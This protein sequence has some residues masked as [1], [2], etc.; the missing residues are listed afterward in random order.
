MQ[1][2]NSEYLEAS[3]GNKKPIVVFAEESSNRCLFYAALFAFIIRFFS[4]FE[5]AG[6]LA[7]ISR[8]VFSSG[9]LS[10]PSTKENRWRLNTA[11]RFRKKVSVFLWLRER[12]RQ[13]HLF[14][15][16]ISFVIIFFDKAVFSSR[17]FSPSLSVPK[18]RQKRGKLS[19]ARRGGKTVFSLA[20]DFKLFRRKKSPEAAEPAGR[21]K[22]GEGLASG[23]P[24]ARD[25][26]SDFA[27]HLCWQFVF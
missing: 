20:E 8:S 17:R 23:D 3:N 10:C 21:G 15:Y 4:S 2:G 19:T 25:S 11:N 5:D 1:Y 9:Q 7:K 18:Q 27:P 16:V 22:G 26:G 14:S 6:S 24:Q 12:W 13:T